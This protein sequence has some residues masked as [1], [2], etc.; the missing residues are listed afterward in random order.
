[1]L[2][3]KSPKE[4]TPEAATTPKVEKPF[5]RGFT[6]IEQLGAPTLAGMMVGN[7]PAQ[8]HDKVHA[9]CQSPETA[10]Q[11]FCLR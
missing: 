2:A 8:H 9:L 3:G 6:R 11:L 1:M 7:V 4:E 5:S 10:L